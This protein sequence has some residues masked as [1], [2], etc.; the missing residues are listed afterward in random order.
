[1]GNL[2]CVL[3]VEH[4]SFVMLL[5]GRTFVG[6]GGA[7]VLN[8]RYIA[9]TVCLSGYSVVLKGLIASFCLSLTHVIWS[10]SLSISAPSSLQHL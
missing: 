9:D 7:R 10:R 3:A 2:L 4:R 5:M 8:R 6:L 1:M